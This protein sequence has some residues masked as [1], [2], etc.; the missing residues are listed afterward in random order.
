MTSYEVNVVRHSIRNTG[1]GR[2]QGREAREGEGEGGGWQA[3]REGEW[4]D[5]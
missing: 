1:R 4:M 3:G 2:A 5:E